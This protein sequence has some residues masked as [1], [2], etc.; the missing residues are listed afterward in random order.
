[1][2]SIDDKMDSKILKGH[3]T[4]GRVIKKKRLEV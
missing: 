1:M 4:I 3:V 2:F